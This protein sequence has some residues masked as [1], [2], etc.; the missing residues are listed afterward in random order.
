VAAPNGR[1]WKPPNFRAMLLS[2]G[3]AGLRSYKGQVVATGTWSPILTRVEWTELSA[4]LNDPTRFRVGRPA[5]HL[6]TGL[7]ACGLCKRPMNAHYR[8]DGARQYACR[9]RPGE[10]S[11]G[12]MAVKAE[13]VDTL[14]IEAVIEHL[15]GPGLRRMLTSMAQ[16]SA[17]YQVLAEELVAAELHRDEVE[18]MYEVGEIKRPA[19]LRMHGPA[20]ERVGK[21][22]RMLAEFN[23]RRALA[24]LPEGAAA[25]RA[26]WE[27][28]ATTTEQ[29]R[30]VL[31]AVLSRVL[32]GP[33]GPRQSKFD[34]ARLLPPYGPQWIA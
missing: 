34:P 14:V 22:R 7:A 18:H 11:C 8:A 15:D 4:V 27:D 10:Q 9:R 13:P 1:P 20:E 28:P 33:C 29:Q 5:N 32:I 25:Q 26:W 21:A 30:A 16:A 3:I 6:L 12:R 23:G 19:F 24:E 31:K 17:E 2:P